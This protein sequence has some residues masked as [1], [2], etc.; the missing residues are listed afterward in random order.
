MSSSFKGSNCD[1]KDKPCVLHSGFRP[2][3]LKRL[4]TNFITFTVKLVIKSQVS[5][6]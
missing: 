1:M 3:W 5:D 4:F 6:D 2:G